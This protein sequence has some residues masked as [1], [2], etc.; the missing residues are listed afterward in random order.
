[1]SHLLCDRCSV[2]GCLLNYDGEP[3]K[4]RRTVEPTNYE[5]ISELESDQMAEFLAWW[6]EGHV[7][8]RE[9]PGCIEEWLSEPWNPDAKYAA[10]GGRKPGW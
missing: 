6:H 3:C 10:N 5:H 8:W 1:M 7:A 4:R 9:D 2:S